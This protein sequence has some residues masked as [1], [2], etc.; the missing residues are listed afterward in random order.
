MASIFRK[1]LEEGIIFIV[2]TTVR[3]DVKTIKNRI[4]QYNSSYL[5]YTDNK[6][7]F[8]KDP[9]IW[10]DD[11][12]TN[13]FYTYDGL[14]P[15]GTKQDVSKPDIEQF[16]LQVSDEIMDIKMSNNFDVDWE[17]FIFSDTKIIIEYYKNNKVFL[18]K[19]TDQNYHAILRCCDSASLY[20][21]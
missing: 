8:Q 18:E 21:Y 14:K 16:Y 10:S 20:Y 6:L 3:K 15:D 2:Q 9:Y 17:N 19:E 11:V 5:G 13:I 7:V 12:E 1:N 4:L